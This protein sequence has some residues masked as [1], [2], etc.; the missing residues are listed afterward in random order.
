MYGARKIACTAK[1]TVPMCPHSQRSR[2]IW[3]GV[4]KP[5]F[6]PNAQTRVPMKNRLSGIT[7]ADDEAI[8]P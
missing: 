8:S 1:I 5:Y 2:N 7:N 4:M 3:T 6:F